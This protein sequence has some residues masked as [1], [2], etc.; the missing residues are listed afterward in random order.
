MG[1]SHVPPC[2]LDE[3]LEANQKKRAHP[4]NTEDW[5]KGNLEQLESVIT[6]DYL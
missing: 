1:A 2:L 5:N 4:A 6:H 3:G